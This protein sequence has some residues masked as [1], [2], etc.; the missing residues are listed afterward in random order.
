MISID[1]SLI[2]IRK[3][4]GPKIDPCGTP[5]LTG[6]HSDIW[7]FK[8]TLWDPRIVMDSLLLITLTIPAKNEKTWRLKNLK[9]T[10]YP[11]KLY[12]YI[13]HDVT[14]PARYY[15]W[16][17]ALFRINS[18]QAIIKSYLS[19][20]SRAK[21]HTSIIFYVVLIFFHYVST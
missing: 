8:T 9:Y 2:Q 7:P 19:V 12:C 13:K 20:N 3:K 11:H 6:N 16:W 14:R 5:A 1:R 18:Q 21:I 4:R 10:L 15:N 17:K